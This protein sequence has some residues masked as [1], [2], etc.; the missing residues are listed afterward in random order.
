M[1]QSDSLCLHVALD[2]LFESSISQF[3]DPVTLLEQTVLLTILSLEHQTVRELENIRLAT[4]AVL[5][6]FSSMFVT[7]S[8]TAL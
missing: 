8:T 6:R 3:V 1:V 4:T 2:D 5:I 7:I